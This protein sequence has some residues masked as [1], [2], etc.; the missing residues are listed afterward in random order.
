[1]G[2]KNLQ[3]LNHFVSTSDLSK[4]IVQ[5]LIDRAIAYKKGASYH[6]LEPKFIAN[7]FFESSTHTRCAF[8]MAEHHLG[9]KQLSFDYETS[10][11]T[12]GASLHDTVVTMCTLGVDVLVIRSDEEQFYTSLLEDKN[13]T[14]TIVNAGDGMGEH[15]V[16]SMI[17]LMTIY[18]H[19]GS[20]EGLKVGIVGDIKHSRVANSDMAMFRRLGMKVYFSGPEV[21]QND[22]CQMYGDYMSMDAL[23]KEVDVLVLLRIQRE[24]HSLSISDETYF[25]DYGL[26][27]DRVGNMKE[28]AIIL[29]PCPINKGVEIAPEVLTL[30]KCRILTQM[31]NGVYMNMAIL[32][33]LL[34]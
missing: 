17:D 32:E 21:F 13:V 26:T 15:P 2:R 23:V 14:C 16:Q 29:H 25:K 18:E 4:E 1:M 20:F 28:K 33:A 34:V 12:K 5:S 22:K 24:R 11:V 7:L 6:F 3:H 8:E 27:L 9:I 31:K 10:S 30:D 19:F